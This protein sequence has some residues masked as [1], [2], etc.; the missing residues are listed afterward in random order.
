MTPSHTSSPTGKV[1]VRSPHKCHPTAKA[2][3]L[4]KKPHHAIWAPIKNQG[5]VGSKS[6]KLK[7]VKAMV[8]TSMTDKP[9]NAELGLTEYELLCKRNIQQNKALLEDLGL[10]PNPL[11]IPSPPPNNKARQLSV[12]YFFS[13]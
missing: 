11:G 9:T 10:F 6:T 12:P 13:T 4:P 1:V 8:S 7:M 5:D 3:A 2:A